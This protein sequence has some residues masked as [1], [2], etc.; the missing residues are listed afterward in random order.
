MNQPLPDN[1]RRLG[2]W[3]MY[4]TW[5]I[6]IAMASYF[7]SNWQQY[8]HNPN[9][10]LSS[11]LQHPVVLKQNAQGHY[12]ASGMINDIAVV[13]LLDTGAT[14]VSIGHKL[15]SKIGLTATG[16][17]RV[18]TANGVITVYPTL[19]DSI[20]LGGLRAKNIEAHIN[21]YAEDNTVLLGMSF[22]KHL[23]LVQQN[24]T[25]TLSAP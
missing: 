3:M 18:S 17:D 25:L 11:D 9:Q 15:A 22:L 12:L 5:V 1:S 19:L 20:S 23:T 6:S 21:P 13:F 8:K 2:K 16:E 4:A 14:D 10:Y 24:N 7:F